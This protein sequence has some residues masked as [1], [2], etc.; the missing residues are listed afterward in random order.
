MDSLVAQIL[1]NFKAACGLKITDSSDLFLTE[2]NLLEFLMKLGRA[3][4]GG[5]FQQL[6]TGYEGAVIRKGNRKYKFMGYR[7]TS[8]TSAAKVGTGALATTAHYLRIAAS[9]VYSTA[10]PLDLLPQL[11]D[12]EPNAPVAQLS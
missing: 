8:R 5:V 10:S 3:A 7:T 9:K 4:M 6:A 2:K 12:A 1:E 11:T